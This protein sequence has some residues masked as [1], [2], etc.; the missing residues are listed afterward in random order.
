[1]I[2]FPLFLI[3]SFA[4]PAEND[5]HSSSHRLHP[6][7]SHRTS[8]IEWISQ[9]DDSDEEEEDDNL[10]PD[11]PWKSLPSQHTS[12]AN[13]SGHR[14]QN[15][16]NVNILP[17]TAQLRRASLS[18]IAEDPQ[19]ESNTDDTQWTKLVQPGRTRSNSGTSTK[20]LYDLEELRIAASLA[21]ARGIVPTPTD[22]TSNISSASSSGTNTHNNPALV[23]PTQD[24]S[25]SS[26]CGCWAWLR[27]MF[28]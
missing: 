16:S 26:C 19:G 27:R 18:M 9:N 28:K 20:D 3:F 17:P 21:A 6:N 25:S 5:S 12:G 24:P 11:H 1:M 13:H 22:T 15:S 23:S 7:P 14:R 4:F 8:T 2:L 10:T